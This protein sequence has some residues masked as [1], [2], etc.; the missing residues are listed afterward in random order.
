MGIFID[1]ILIAILLISA[2][3]G[4]KK[5]LVKLGA[6]LIA[7]IIAIIITIIAYKPFSE[8]IIK[9]TN[10]DNKIENIILE[11]TNNFI[12]EKTEKNNI[13]TD[14]I[15]NKLLPDEAKNMSK[16][17]V[18]AIS[19]VILFVIVKIVLSVIISLLN[20]VANLPILKQFNEIGGIIYG[21]LRGLLLVCILIIIIGVV[22]KMNPENKLNDGIQN[23]YLSKFVYEKIVKF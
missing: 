21:T 5:G 4:Y 18:Y 9:N 10:I 7:G 8:A 20:G 15:Q 12:N 22:T 23:S 14:Q 13:V 1:I 19:A 17:I 11:N 16:G 6:R 3:L 2:F